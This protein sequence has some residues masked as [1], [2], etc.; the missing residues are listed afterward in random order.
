VLVVPGGGRRQREPVRDLRLRRRE[1]LP[2][3]WGKRP[4]RMRAQTL[5]A[6]ASRNHANRGGMRVWRVRDGPTAA[7]P[8]HG[9]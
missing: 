6:A 8:P 2:Q 7:A 5:R 9:P 3:Q 1:M 4:P